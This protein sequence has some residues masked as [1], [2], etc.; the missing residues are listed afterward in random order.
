MSPH[1]I[2]GPPDESTPNLWN[3]CRL[4]R[5]LTLSNFVMLRQEVLRHPLSKIRAPRKSGTKF[6]I[7][8]Y[9]LL[10]TNVSYCAKFD[11]ARPNDVRK[12][13]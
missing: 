5:S 11:R 1:G 3:K 12:K 4:A 8:A 2:M 13:C 6:T 9:Y 10:H 7:I